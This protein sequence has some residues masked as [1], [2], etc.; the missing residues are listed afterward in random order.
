MLEYFT[1]LLVFTD[2]VAADKPV[3][4]EP[5]SLL[6]VHAGKG[7]GQR[8]SLLQQGEGDDRKVSRKILA[9]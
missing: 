8:G 7:T 4:Q 6:P 5:L 1:F 2:S 3:L 9:D